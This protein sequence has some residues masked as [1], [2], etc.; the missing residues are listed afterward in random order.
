MPIC[1]FVEIAWG[2]E[3]SDTECGDAAFHKKLDGNHKLV[4]HGPATTSRD[5]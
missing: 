2:N 5:K 1:L 3:K 4:S